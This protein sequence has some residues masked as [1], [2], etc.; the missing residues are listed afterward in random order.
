MRSVIRKSLALGAV[1]GTG[2]VAYD[3]FCG[4]A[5]VGAATR[6][7]H[8]DYDVVVVGGGIVGAATAREIT[9]RHPKL[10]VAIVEK[11]ADVARHQTGHNSGVIHAGIYYQPGSS[12]ARLC[13]RGADLVYQYCAK[14]KVPHERVGKLIVACDESEVPVLHDLHK[15]GTANGV[16]VAHSNPLQS[17][18]LLSLCLILCNF[19][20]PSETVSNPPHLLHPPT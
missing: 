17:S 5:D 10:H 3:T 8:G 18:P 9:Q 13:V 4:R 20:Q 19:F 14:H 1:A 11:E 16:K 15:R 12:M 6:P 2:Y 7:L